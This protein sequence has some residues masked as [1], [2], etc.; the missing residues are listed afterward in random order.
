M[1]SSSFRALLVAQ[2]LGALN[3]NFFKVVVSLFVFQLISASSSAQS[4]GSLYL[5][6]VQGTFILPF[7]LFSLQ[8]GYFSDKYSKTVVIRI[9]KLVELIV[10]VLGLMACTAGSIYGMLLV[11]FLMGAHSAFFSPAKYGALPE[12]LESDEL[13]QGNGY[14]EFWTFA[15]IILGTALGG[16]SRALF[17]DSM[18]VQGIIMVM[19]ASFGFISTFFIRELSPANPLAKMENNPVQFIRSTLHEIKLNRGLYLSFLG[20]IYFWSLGMLFHSNALLYAKNVLQL[21]DLGTGLFLTALACGIGLG[22]IIAGKASLGKVELG[23]VPIG[24]FLMTISCMGLG[25]KFGIITSFGFFA[26]LGVGVGFFM[27]P[28]NSYFQKE[29]PAETLGRYL[30]ASNVLSYCGM[31]VGAVLFWLITGQ[32]GGSSSLLFVFVGG[33]TLV[34]TIWALSIL[35]EVAIRCINWMISQLLYSTKIIGLENLPKTGGALLVCNHVSYMDAC[36]LLAASPRPIRFLMFKPIYDARLINPV[37]KAMKAIP[38]AA[39]MNREQVNGALDEAQNAIRQ[40]ELVCIFAEGAIT[41]LGHLLPFRRGLERIMKDLNA[42]IVPIY[43]DQLWGS[44]FSFSGGKFLWKIPKEIPYPISI[45]FGEKLLPTDDA[46][47][48]AAFRVRQ[49][50]EELS[51]E[52]FKFRRRRHRLLHEASLDQLKRMPFRKLMGDAMGSYRAWEVLCGML[53]LRKKLIPQLLNDQKNIGIL[54]PSSVVGVMTNLA[55]L[56]LKKVPVNLNFTA[57]EEAFKGAL[58]KAQIQTVIS[59]RVF[60]KNVDVPP[61]PSILFVEDLF[62]EI[63]KSE[64]TL[65][66]LISLLLPRKLIQLLFCPKDVKDSD[67]ATIMFSSGSTGEPKGVMLSHA[68]ITSNVESI[69]EVFEFKKDDGILGVLPFFHS[70]GFTGTIFLPLLGGLR[71]FYLPNPLDATKIGE[72]VKKERLTILLTTPTFL[73]AYTR[74]CDADQFKS[75]R[76]VVVGAEKLKSNIREAFYDKFK[77]DPLEGYGC[78]ELS[79][80]AMLNI[81]DEGKQ[82]GNKPGTVGHPIPGVTVKVVDRETGESLK[83]GE[84]GLLYIKGPNVMLGYLGDKEQ[85]AK[86]IKDGW[87]F[88][89]DVGEVDDEGFVTITDRIS[90]FS[91]IGGEM[92]PHIR[93]EEEILSILAEKEQSCVVTAVQ[94]DKKGEKLVVLSLKE[95]A[96][97]DVIKQLAERGLPNLWIPKAEYFAV[98]DSFPYLASGKLDLQKIRK[99][100][101]EKFCSENI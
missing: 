33:I 67:L 81:H 53:I 26:L 5:A 55:L 47:P 69:F 46:K 72:I 36:L 3:D 2:F 96:V 68:N 97:K 24:A 89:G 82:T 64:K 12:L 73:Q 31:L 65:Y 92:V 40:G 85:T 14:L 62:G 59:S 57:S 84:S 44:V 39:G 78:T 94:D 42:P 6:L 41:R 52:S 93:I 100:A 99:I 21:E 25:L 60:L 95:I 91:K 75:L 101:V 88:T 58:N 7:I 11:L 71:A 56:F 51:A 28:L 90:R 63:P 27:V 38:I 45:H 16:F 48:V 19:I 15:A 70:F 13:S 98:I 4:N 8:S 37:A 22:S 34:V 30:A 80:I 35:P 20:I 66:A 23:L 1:K 76:Y 79:P 17:K 61:L 83:P 49:A 18:M 50:V 74:K 77:L 87:Y 29:S 54:L 9:T 43:I 10:S 32:L 86:V